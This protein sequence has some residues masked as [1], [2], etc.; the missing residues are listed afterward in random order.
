MQIP[1]KLLYTKEHEW[2]RIEGKTATIGITDFA[3]S[4]LGDITFADLP[5][6]GSML[7]Q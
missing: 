1:E 7:E 3:Q 6:V 4:S 2:A 5:K